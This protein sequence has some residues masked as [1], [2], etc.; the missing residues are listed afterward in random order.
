MSALRAIP[1]LQDA[2]WEY[3]FNREN[4]LIGARLDELTGVPT[5]LHPRRDHYN[6]LAKKVGV[7]SNEIFVGDGADLP[8]CEDSRVDAAFASEG[9]GRGVPRFKTLGDRETYR[10]N[11]ARLRVGILTQ[12]GNAAGYN[13]V[14]DSIVKRHAWLSTRPESGAQTNQ[15]GRAHV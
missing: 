1:G 11:P 5:H 12:G 9:A 13:I 2:G 4:R 14:I 7:A 10:L 3:L 15:I 6:A 8:A